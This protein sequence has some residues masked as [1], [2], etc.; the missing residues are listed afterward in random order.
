M[1]ISLALLDRVSF[2]GLLETV[3]I[4]SFFPILISTITMWSTLIQ[5]ICVDCFIHLWFCLI[6]YSSQVPVSTGFYSITLTS[7]LFSYSNHDF[8]VAIYIKRAHLMQVTLTRLYHTFVIHCFAVYL[9]FV[10]FLLS[11][12]IFSSNLISAFLFLLCLILHQLYSIRN[13]FKL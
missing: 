13:K 4:C 7:S 8:L 11:I 9:N 3:L 10:Y 12:I 5:H 2:S 6:C 1:Q